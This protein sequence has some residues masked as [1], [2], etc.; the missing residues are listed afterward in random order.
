M[1]PIII[2]RRNI[3]NVWSV[4]IEPPVPGMQIND[5]V[6]DFNGACGYAAAMAAGL[7]R[8]V[9]MT[10]TSNEAECFELVAGALIKI[11]I[12]EVIG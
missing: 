8:L 1:H 3:G 2:L 11:A 9:D 5:T 6:D 12:D 7:R 10:G 4:T